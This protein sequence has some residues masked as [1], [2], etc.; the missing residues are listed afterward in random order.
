MMMSE[1]GRGVRFD[2]LTNPE[3][4]AA[5]SERP[6]V[7]IPCGSTEQHGPHLPTGTDIFASNVIGHAVAEP[8]PDPARKMLDA[9]AKGALA[10]AAELMRA[11]GSAL[12][13]RLAPPSPR[14]LDDAVAVFE[15]AVAGLRRSGVTRDL[16][17]DALGRVF[18][19][20]FSLDQLR[21]NLADLLDRAA[22]MA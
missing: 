11:A 6:L 13:A 9:P 2:E 3:I 21:Q 7:L 1:R 19:L 15:V 12:T 20:A 14:D 5:L 16:A 4:V 8:P 18:A 22:E 17:D 10:A